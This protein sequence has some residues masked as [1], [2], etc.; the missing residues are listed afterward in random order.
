MYHNENHT[1]QLIYWL[2][3]IAVQTVIL[4]IRKINNFEYL[5]GLTHNF[6]L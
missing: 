3:Y 5:F 1:P 4:I 2:N 6:V